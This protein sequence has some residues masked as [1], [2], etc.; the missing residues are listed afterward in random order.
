MPT[1]EKEHYSIQLSN[2]DLKRLD[3]QLVERRTAQYQ[4]SDYTFESG[5]DDITIEY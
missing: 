2:T 5:S 3:A 1:G 4:N